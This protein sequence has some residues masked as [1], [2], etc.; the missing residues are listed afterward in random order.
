MQVGGPEAAVYDY[1]R[2]GPQWG[3]DALVIGPP[4]GAVMGG[5]AGP[6]NPNRGLGDLRE[7]RCRLG[8]AYEKLPESVGQTSLFGGDEKDAKVAEL[9]VFYAP[10]IAKLF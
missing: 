8:L 2:G 6:D 1:V 4:V 5:L 9:M 7:A 3:S 10:E